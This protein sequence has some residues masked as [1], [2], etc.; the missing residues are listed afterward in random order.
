[1]RLKTLFRSSLYHDDQIH[2]YENFFYR[3]MTFNSPAIQTLISKR[4]PARIA[5]SYVNALTYAVR[6]CPGKTL[7]L[8]LGGGG[9][10]HAC[11][12]VSM[13]AVECNPCVIDLAQRYFYLER[14]PN[15]S[16]TCDDAAHFLQ[17]ESKT[18]QHI[19]VDVYQEDTLPSSCR[20][21]EFIE[22]CKHCLKEDGVLAFNLTSFTKQ[23]DIFGHIQAV[24]QDQTILF[25]VT[26]SSNV[27]ILGFQLHQRALWIQKM[28]A[29]QTIKAL[30]FD[31]ELGIVARLS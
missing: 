17:E 30:T 5:L 9:V 21:L 2:L 8:G 14:L 27:I 16:I 13:H 1:M 24:F 7:L 22:D 11:P 25:P 15:L 18:W 10:A 4:N 6:H 20:T 26:R 29:D 31:A 12:D 23:M 3:W 28:Q 19:L